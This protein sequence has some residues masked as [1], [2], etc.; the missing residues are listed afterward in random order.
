MAHGTE[1]KITTQPRADEG[2][3][4]L[5]H[6]AALLPSLPSSQMH[7][8]AQVSCPLLVAVEEGSAIKAR[9]TAAAAKCHQYD[10][11]H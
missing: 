3:E 10:L 5:R 7:H 2:S 9:A 4:Y 11:D 1:D 6:F 8:R